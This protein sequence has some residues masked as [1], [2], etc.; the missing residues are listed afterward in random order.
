MT[1]PLLLTARPMQR[2]FPGRAD[3][4]ARAREFTKRVLGPC[5]VTDE[6]V[7]LVSELAS[8]ALEHT[9]TRDG[10]QFRVTICRTTRRNGS[11]R[12]RVRTE[13]SFC[14]SQEEIAAQGFDLSINRYREVIRAQVEHRAPAEILDELEHIET[15]IQQG[16]SEL[17]RMLG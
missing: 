9:S 10:G 7:L 13:P 3:Q 16:M 17:K 4:I 2:A 5:R 14:V 1:E 6:A 12:G 11:E 15:S 8:N